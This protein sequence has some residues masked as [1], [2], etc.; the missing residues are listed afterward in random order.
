MQ[1]IS[2]KHLIS[3]V[4]SAVVIVI[5]AFPN[6]ADAQDGDPELGKRLWLTTANCKDCHGSLANGVQE[7]PQEPQGYNLRESILTPEEMRDTVRCG[8]IAGLMPYFQRSAWT[9]RGLCYGMTAADI[10]D[11]AMPDRADRMLADRSLDALIAFIFK[12]FVGNTLITFESC[13]GLL[14]EGN[15]KC[16]EFSRK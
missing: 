11:D 16:K 13:T 10:G 4:I 12:E 2:R 8:R 3:F 6:T 9:E 5:L 14:G 7:I 1:S 15:S